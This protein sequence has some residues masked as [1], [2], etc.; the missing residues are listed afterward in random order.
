VKPR[1]FHPHLD[2][3]GCR[4]ALAEAIGQLA[5]GDAQGSREQFRQQAA[6]P[7]WCGPQD[8]QRVPCAGTCHERANGP[9]V[10]GFELQP[11]PRQQRADCTLKQEIEESLWLPALAGR[12]PHPSG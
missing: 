12:Q 5:A 1:V 6:V 3:T 9:G 8:E 10:T 2:H 7:P 11:A 4:R